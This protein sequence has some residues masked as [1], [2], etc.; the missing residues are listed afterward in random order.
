MCAGVL[1]AERQVILGVGVGSSDKFPTMLAHA[2][3]LGSKAAIS[4]EAPIKQTTSK[5]TSNK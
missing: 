4:T 1:R 2:A 3:E 5:S